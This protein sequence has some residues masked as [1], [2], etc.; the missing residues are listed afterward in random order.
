MKHLT[1]EEVEQSES[2]IT[3]LQELYNEVADR[4]REKH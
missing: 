3:E 1:E 2:W 4:D